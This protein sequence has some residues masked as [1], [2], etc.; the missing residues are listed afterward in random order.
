MQIVICATRFRLPASGPVIILAFP[1]VGASNVG[2]LLC[3]CDPLTQTL[4][5]LRCLAASQGQGTGAPSGNIVL[6]ILYFVLQETMY[7]VCYT[8]LLL[9]CIVLCISFRIHCTYYRS[10]SIHVCNRRYAINS[11]HNIVYIVIYRSTHNIVILY[12]IIS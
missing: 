10:T 12:I 4:F 6:C 2:G 3:R 8:L 1:L 7:Y 11:T 5:V 9:A